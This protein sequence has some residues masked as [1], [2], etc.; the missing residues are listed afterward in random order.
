MNKTTV[1][2]LMSKDVE[3]VFEDE[4]MDLAHTILTLGRI[5]HLP[6]TTRDGILIGLVTQRDL[7][8]TMSRLYRD[9]GPKGNEVSLPITEMMTKNV[10]TVGPNESAYQAAELLWEHKYGCLPVVE[11]HRL[12][13]I[14]T[15]SDFVRY[16]MR[17]L[18]RK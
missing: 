2:D 11:D 18:L 7:A 4:T 1:N 5:R 14:I 15:E 17:S 10:A 8:R 16:A 9:F 6:V 13:G 3:S 12:V